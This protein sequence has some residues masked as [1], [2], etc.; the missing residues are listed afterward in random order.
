MKTTVMGALLAAA[1]AIAVAPGANAT[2]FC[3]GRGTIIAVGTSNGVTGGDVNTREIRD[4]IDEAT[5]VPLV[6]GDGLPDFEGR[7]YLAVDA[8]LSHGTTFSIWL[9]VEE[10]GL[11]GLQRGGVTTLGEAD[12]CQDGLNPDFGVF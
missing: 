3:N 8:V 11:P 12:V 1:C 2:D 7:V 5:G 9:Y 4:G 10:N 6:G